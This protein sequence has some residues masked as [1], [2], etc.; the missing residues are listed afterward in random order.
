MS[1]CKIM[2]PQAQWPMPFLSSDWINALLSNNP[3]SWASNLEIFI[4][5][6]EEEEV[7]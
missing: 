3:N 7:N 6:G 5:K 1:K 4:K 2:Y